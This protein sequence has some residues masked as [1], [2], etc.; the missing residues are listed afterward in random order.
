MQKLLPILFILFFAAAVS[1]QYPKLIIQ[2]RDKGDNTFSISDPSKFLSARSLE[3]R[4]R[5]KIGYDSTDLPV[6]FR[7][8]DSIRLAGN[9]TVLST[10]KWL[11]QVLVLST[12]AAA[13]AKIQSFPFVRSVTGVGFRV[14]GTQDP[15]DDKFTEEIKS[16][17]RSGTEQKTQGDLINYGNSYSQVHIHE[18]EFLHN[19]GFRGENKLITVLDAGFAQYKSVTAFDSLRQNGQI[20]GERDYVAFDNSVN[21]DDSHGMYCFSIMGA[22]WPGRM[23]GTAPKAS[24]W[25]VRTENATGEY[26]IEEHNWVVGAEFADSTGSDMISSSLGYY[27]FDAP[28]F[29]HSYADFYRNTTPVTKGASLAA[30]KGIIV[31]NSAGNE[32]NNSW[33]Y[34][35][36]PADADSVCAVGAVN[37]AGQIANFSSYGYPGKIKP[38]I[39]SVGAGTVIAGL[40]N[41]PQ[42]GNGTSYANPNVAG[43]I[44]CLWQA[45]PNLTNM[46]ILDAVYKSADRY[47]SPTDRYGFGIPNFR[48]AYVALKTE[49]NVARY[50]A[51]WLFAT[52]DPFTTKIDVKVLGQ[53]DGRARVELVNSA[54]QVI[55]TRNL[56]SEIQE[57]YDLSFDS[58]GTVQAGNY[59][60][61]YTDSLRT[62][63]VNLSK[64]PTTTQG[65]W[66]IAG[67]NPFN[68]AL[69]VSVTPTETG[70]AA[71]MLIDAKGSKVDEIRIAATT[72]VSQT[73]TFR[74]AAQLPRGVYT[75]VYRGNKVERSLRMLKL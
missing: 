49:E 36:F 48:K 11:N 37:N 6:S 24:Y 8:I 45:F 73:L 50:G 74:N 65:D 70:P 61:R 18:G 44:A 23:V 42:T 31:M 53:V 57:V 51:D 34:L 47:T 1:A 13:L 63:Q 69:T 40:N 15:V 66:L 68:T 17:T 62:R 58:L 33:K 41:Q 7:Y 3:R 16:I 54:N 9:V 12:D 39:V 72:G 28:A 56:A 26:P 67:P 38:N 2:L 64:L 19:K 32:G 21:E 52:P 27:D 25:L 75:L 71:I 20:L 10:S 55:A 29:N 43:L 4:A 46:K 35:S 59:L 5:Q 14:R 22:N 60:V 30:R